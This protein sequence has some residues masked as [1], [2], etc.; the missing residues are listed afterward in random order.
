M[1]YDAI[2]TRLPLRALFDLKGKRDVLR[3]WCGDTLPPFPDHPNRLT[4]AHGRQLVH[5]GPGCWILM[6]SLAVEQALTAA[7]RPD[8]APG[9]LSVV[10]ISDMLTFFAVTGPEASDVMAVA[11]PLDLHPRVFPPDGAS[12]T[13]AFGIRALI[14]RIAGGYE[15]AVERS[16]ADWFEEA[17]VRTTA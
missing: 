16:Y 8:E 6:A 10:P 3:N 9:D 12:W 1:G 14:R 2:I 4:E 15:M 11:T 17:L 5:T 7:L 13:E